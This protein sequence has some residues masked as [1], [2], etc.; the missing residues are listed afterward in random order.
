MRRFL[1]ITAAAVISLLMQP[2]FAQQ[3][4]AGTKA[5]P[6][7][8]PAPRPEE[9]DKHFAKMQERMATMQAQMDRIRQAKDAKERQRLMQQHWTTMQDTMTLMHGEWSGNATGGPM[10]GS[11][12]M[13]GPMTWGQ[14]QNLTPEQL[15]QRQYMMDRWMPMQEMMMD[16]MMQHHFWMLQPQLPEAPKR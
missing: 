9:V 6:P 2:A 11:N 4:A 7:V 15:K 13:G 3:P 12:M 14:Y 1:Q 8:Q 10:M 16:Q 5:A